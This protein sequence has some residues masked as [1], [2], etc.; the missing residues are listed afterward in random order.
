M[1]HPAVWSVLL[2]YKHCDTVRERVREGR[3]WLCLVYTS[4]QSQPTLWEVKG[5][6]VPAAGGLPADGQTWNGQD[7]TCS[8]GEICLNVSGF[9]DCYSEGRKELYKLL[10]VFTS[11]LRNHGLLSH[12]SYIPAYLQACRF[13]LTLLC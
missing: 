11:S 8:A 4:D 3:E 13:C 10:S 6:E 1:R 2:Y 5:D 9:C 7:L 12:L